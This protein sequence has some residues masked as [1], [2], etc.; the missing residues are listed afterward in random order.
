MRDTTSASTWA[1]WGEPSLDDLMADPIVHA[2][3]R[4]D[5]LDETCVRQVAARAAERLR[6]APSH[7]AAP[8]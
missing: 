4:R 3:M 1:L 2:V 7:A 8:A 6:Q 5:G